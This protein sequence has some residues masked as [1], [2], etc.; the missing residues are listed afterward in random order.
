[1]TNVEFENALALARVQDMRNTIDIL[2]AC[3]AEG[4]PIP[5]AEHALVRRTVRDWERRLTETL[6]VRKSR[7]KEEP[8]PLLRG[9]K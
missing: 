9:G 8:P 1:M 3:V 2:D 7:A 5:D 6:S 4:G